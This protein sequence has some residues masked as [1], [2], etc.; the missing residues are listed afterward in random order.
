MD[1]V[2]AVPNANADA[3]SDA[4]N[5][6]KLNEIGVADKS[7][8]MMRHVSTTF[9]NGYTV[10]VNHEVSPWISAEGHSPLPITHRATKSWYI[11]CS[12]IDLAKTEPQLRICLQKSAVTSS[13]GCVTSLPSELQP[14]LAPKKQAE[15]RDSTFTFVAGPDPIEIFELL[16]KA[17]DA[18]ITKSD[19]DG[20]SKMLA[21]LFPD[22]DF[23][24]FPLYNMARMA[25]YNKLE[26]TDLFPETLHALCKTI[27]FPFRMIKGAV[28][29]PGNISLK[30]APRT[31]TAE[32]LAS[33]ALPME[34]RVRRSLDLL[35]NDDQVRRS[36]R[37]PSPDLTK[38]SPAEKSY[39]EAYEAAGK[40]PALVE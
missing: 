37:T 39:E 23:L 31:L 20:S 14:F 6:V 3:D 35:E 1:G 34:E 27:G 24:I 33:Y 2:D 7:T 40:T 22:M 17:S 18:V 19:K 30:P 15:N 25:V 10:P 32:Q 8:D 26:M 9:I 13:D 16:M 36:G 12:F 4:D 38:E 5:P 21:E 11:M 28:V 29:R